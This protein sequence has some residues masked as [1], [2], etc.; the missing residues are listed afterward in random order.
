MS[1]CAKCR[2]MG[3]NHTQA[4]KYDPGVKDLKAHLK[5]LAEG[6]LM[7][8]YAGGKEWGVADMCAPEFNEAIKGP[9]LVVVMVRHGDTWAQ[10]D[11]HHNYKPSKK[12]RLRDL[13]GEV[14][15]LT[16]ALKQAKKLHAVMV[17][18]GL[19][20][21]AAALEPLFNGDLGRYNKAANDLEALLELR[22]EYMVDVGPALELVCRNVDA[23]GSPETLL[24]ALRQTVNEG[25]KEYLR[26]NP[27]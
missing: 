6:Y 13:E 4:T 3:R 8:L 10:L 18:S 20:K 2:I 9:V 21:R 26:T 17:G 23:K 12:Q 5:G 27:P 19:K 11:E 22:D 7:R 1:C 24:K 25:A 15:G 16:N 14:S